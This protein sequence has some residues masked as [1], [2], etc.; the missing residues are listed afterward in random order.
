MRATP[1]WQQFFV[2]IFKYSLSTGPSQVKNWDSINTG[3]LFAPILNSISLVWSLSLQVTPRCGF[4]PPHHLSL[5]KN[6]D[7][8]FS[9]IRSL[10]VN[11]FAYSLGK[12]TGIMLPGNSSQGKSSS[13]I[14]WAFKVEVRVNIGKDLS[15]LFISLCISRSAVNDLWK[16][17][18]GHYP[19]LKYINL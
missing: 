11:T 5:F 1:Y 17:F 4:W 9:S 15:H 19:S 8:L 14:T 13:W 6:I 7:D 3:G 10:P 2:C 16:P 18:K 12:T